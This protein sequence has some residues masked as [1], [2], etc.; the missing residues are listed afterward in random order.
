MAAH[1]F[2]IS[3]SGIEGRNDKGQRGKQIATFVGFPLAVL[4]ALPQV[5]LYLPLP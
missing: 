5:F 1:P 4:H 3:I 2:Y